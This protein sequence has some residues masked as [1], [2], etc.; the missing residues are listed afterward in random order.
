[1]VG[2]HPSPASQV[3][4]SRRDSGLALAIFGFHLVARSRLFYL[5][6]GWPASHT[7]TKARPGDDR[8]GTERPLRG[9]R[10]VRTT[11]FE[12]RAGRISQIPKRG[13]DSRRQ[14]GSHPEDD[15]KTTPD[16]GDPAKLVRA[17]VDSRAGGRPRRLMASGSAFRKK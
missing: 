8:C 2:F 12:K 9:A 15:R 16:F 6:D 11:L 17:V 1:M 4:G 7:A 5:S 3:T 13:R 14:G 10:R